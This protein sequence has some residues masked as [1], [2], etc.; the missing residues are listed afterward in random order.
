VRRVKGPNVAG[1]RTPWPGTPGV[2]AT[3][4][5]STLLMRPPSRSLAMELGI[6][7]RRSGGTRPR[8]TM[9]LELDALSGEARIPG[10]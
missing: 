1:A 6:S 7:V 9:W 10:A 4:V 3:R 2:E 8:R 5:A